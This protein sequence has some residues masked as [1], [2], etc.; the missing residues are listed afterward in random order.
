[1][2]T[3]C[4]CLLAASPK[5]DTL[6]RLGSE[7]NNKSEIMF[8]VMDYGITTIV[9]SSDDGTIFCQ[10]HETFLCQQCCCC[11]LLAASPKT[12]ILN[13]LDSESYHFR[14]KSE[15]MFLVMDYGITTIVN[16]SDGGT[17]FG[18]CHETFLCPHA[19]VLLFLFTCCEPK[20]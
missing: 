18:Q 12:D 16:S 13:Q 3:M 17:I 4:Y 15:I 10:C 5:T 1:M 2:K 14:N 9:N 7:I 20:N 11:C 6:N 8:L 19:T